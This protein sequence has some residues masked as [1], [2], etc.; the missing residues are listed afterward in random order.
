MALAVRPDAECLSDVC[1]CSDEVYI[2]HNR[3]FQVLVMSPFFRPHQPYGEVTMDD[4]RPYFQPPRYPTD[5]D[6]DSDTRLTPTVSLDS[7]PSEP[8]YLSYHVETDSSE[9]SYLSVIR[10]TSDSSSSS[11]TPR[12]TPPLVRG[13]G[14]IRTRAVPRERGHARGGGHGDVAP[15]G[16][17]NNYVSP[18]E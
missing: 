13:R 16:F 5:G 14:F 18:D 10:L 1:E 11:A 17:G 2:F 9:L 6:S 8:S 12:H 4:I 15:G 3:P 7:D